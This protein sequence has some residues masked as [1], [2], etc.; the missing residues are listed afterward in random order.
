MSPPARPERDAC[1]LMAEVLPPGDVERLERALRGIAIGR[2]Q[3]NCR[4]CGCFLRVGALT[5]VCERCA[6]KAD[7]IDTTP[8]S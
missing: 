2:D 5:P 8:A 6:A 7:R 1:A 3:R 4:H